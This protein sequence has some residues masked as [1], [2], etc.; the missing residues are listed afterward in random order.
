MLP[1]AL[2][3]ELMANAWPPALDERHDGWRFR[4]ADGVTRRANSVLAVGG[5][6]RLVE[7]VGL[8]E[9]FYRSRGAAVLFQVSIASAAPSLGD[10]LTERGYRSAARTL[11][12]Q[13]ATRDVV[14]RTERATNWSIEVTDH[15]TDAWFDAYWAVESTRGRSPGDAAICRDVLLAPR[16]PTV[17][18]A[19]RE[20]S[21]V[22][23]V[24]QIVTEEGWAGMQCMATHPGHRR[25]G[26]ASAVLH[27]LALEALDREVEQMYLAVMA[28][29]QAALALYHRANF[30]VTHDYSYF[31]RA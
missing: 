29:N 24:G 5:G 31:A 27:Q 28:D 7:L 12:A 15:P 14:G 17:F 10:H 30:N 22:I 26:A 1:S 18:V 3:D 16:H 13:A 11:V 8:A 23:A 4:W 6:D 19:V 21:D 25:R 2:L 20:G 9:G